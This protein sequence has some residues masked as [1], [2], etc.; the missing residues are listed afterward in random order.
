[1]SNRAPEHW[2]TGAVATVE[3]AVTFP[4][5]VLVF[6]LVVQGALYVHARDVVLGAAREGAHTAAMEH[7]T[8]D[9]ALLDG[10][11]RAQ[12]I[13]VAGLG[14]YA[15]DIPVLPAEDD[16]GNVVVDIA[17]SFPLLLP[18]PGQGGR[19]TVPLVARARASREVFRPQGEGGY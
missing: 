13:L 3:A 1:M 11:S 7:D 15:R 2:R 19:L 9:A 8:I 16:G 4:L 18:G 6:L 14:R 17:G 10:Q 12:A 5:V